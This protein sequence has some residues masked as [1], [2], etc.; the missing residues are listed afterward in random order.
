MTW[1][2]DNV[3]EDP[4]PRVRSSDPVDASTREALESILHGDG[5]HDLDEPGPDNSD[6]GSGGRVDTDGIATPPIAE[7]DVSAVVSDPVA[8]SGEGGEWEAIVRAEGA[9]WR[10]YQRPCV[11]AQL[12]V[13]GGAELEHRLGREAAAVVRAI[14]D[15][16]V[17]T[18]TRE[19]DRYRA[20]SAWRVAGLL[21]EVD[22]VGAERALERVKAAFASSIGPALPMRLAVGWATPARSGT[23]SAAL[24]DAA[25]SLATDVR[26]IRAQAASSVRGQD[27]PSAASA[28]QGTP[29]GPDHGETRRALET[30]VGLLADDLISQAEYESKRAEV[31]ARL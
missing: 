20:Q 30:L 31:L 9:R 12:E 26:G 4:P 6:A 22:E 16:V 11:A 19:S 29:V 3:R 27:R 17:A 14:L 13:V 15:E 7:T 21:I 23:I 8:S 5:A 18:T 1:A 10:R 28:G 24:N 25:R 2:R